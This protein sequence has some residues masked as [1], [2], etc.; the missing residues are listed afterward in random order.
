MFRFKETA[1]RIRYLTEGEEKRLSECLAPHHA[2]LVSFALN[3]GLRQKEQF[4][5][6]WEHTDT[7]RRVLTIPRSKSGGIRHVPLN[8]EALA[9]VWSL[10]SWMT[11]PWVFPS[12]NPATP[13]DCHHVYGRIYMPAVKKAGLQ[14]VNWHT[15]RHTFA[16]RLV[17]AGVDIRTI[18]ELMGHK[19][20]VMTTR[21]SHLSDVHKR[22]EIGRAS[23]RERV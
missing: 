2:K 9:V 7:E 11:S 12:Q 6:R 5:L 17:M 16:S 1:G 13:L 18:Q 14:D 4:E 20:I 21:Y 8:N 15:L 3:T 22:E 19:S 23:C 10:P